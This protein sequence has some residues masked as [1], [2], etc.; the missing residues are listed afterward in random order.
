MVEHITFHIHTID[1]TLSVPISSAK[2]DFISATPHTLTHFRIEV[3][4]NRK[5][6]KKRVKKTPSNE[7]TRSGWQ[8][9]R[10]KNCCIVHFSI[11]F[12]DFSISLFLRFF[13]LALAFVIFFIFDRCRLRFVHI[14]RL[15]KWIRFERTY[16]VST[17][18]ALSQSQRRQ[19][20]KRTAA[21]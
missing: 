6:K 7:L 8:K 19:I 4:Q 1:K 21:R 18:I 2:R 9:S 16:V 14:R 12:N 15:I 20:G 10:K 5:K 13:L 3:K 17:T 11:G